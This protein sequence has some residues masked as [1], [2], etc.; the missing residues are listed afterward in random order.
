MNSVNKYIDAKKIC[1]LLYKR[2]VVLT[3][4]ST[5][6]FGGGLQEWDHLKL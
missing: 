6:I 4:S 5:G 1:L 3:V 2:G